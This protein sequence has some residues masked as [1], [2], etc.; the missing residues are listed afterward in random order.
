MPKNVS[1]DITNNEPNNRPTH[2]AVDD[3]ILIRQI[4][5]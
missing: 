4:F 2:I 5:G 1:A 3:S